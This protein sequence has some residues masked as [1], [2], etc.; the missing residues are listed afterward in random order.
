MSR[1]TGEAT[2]VA[3]STIDGTLERVEG[4]RQYRK[5][6]RFNTLVFREDGGA[7]RTIKNALAAGDVVAELREGNRGRF[8]TFTALDVRGVHGVR[9]RD[10]TTRYAFPGSN[11]KLF[12]TLVIISLIVLVI[13]AVIGDGLPLIQLLLT[14][15]IGI[16]W[17]LTQK[18][19]SEA[20]AQFDDDAA[21]S[22]AS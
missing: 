19:E 14:V 18:S 21:R 20:R 16:G 17:Y 3:V 9:T 10:G 12:L 5:V 6:T 1:G 22:G 4:A 11:A 8:Y 7:S 2:L 15:A 13:R